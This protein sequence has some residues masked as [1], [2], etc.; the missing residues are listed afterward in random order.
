LL[1]AQK[2]EAIGVLAGGIAHDFNNILTSMIGFAQMLQVY[3]ELSPA[4]QAGLASIEREGQRAAHLIRQ[5]LDF[6]RRSASAPQSLDLAPF[7]KELVKFLERA[8]PE[9]IRITLDLAPGEYPVHA[10]PIQLQQVVTNLAVNARDAMPTGG[11]LRLGLARFTLPPATLAPCPGMAPGEW[12]VL[13]VTDTG[14]GIPADVLPHLY[15]PFFTTK[16]VGQGTGLGLAQVYGI[17][18]QH[19]G[20]IDVETAVGRGTTFRVYL[21]RH[22]GAGAPTTP[23]QTTPL[24][25]GQGQTILLV[26]DEE[27]VRQ[28]GQR[29]L[30][31]LGYQVLTAPNGRAALAV[32][33]SAARVDLLITDL[34]MP[35]MGGIELLRQLQA[36]DPALKVLALTGYMAD[37]AI[38]DLAGVAVQG[39]IQKPFDLAT[40]AEIVHRV[41]AAG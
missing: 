25:Q 37:G 34:V 8:I 10:D 28:L 13:A 11:E 31:S 9:H 17:V 2:M 33:R 35:E 21:P 4:A 5:M 18:Q 32:Y 40:L 30:E 7:L 26:E 24:P 16:E 36:V 29:V 20:F 12:V 38:S 19:A 23:T 27:T 22:E 15:E 6:S 3:E 39:V 1:Q 41:L 14:T